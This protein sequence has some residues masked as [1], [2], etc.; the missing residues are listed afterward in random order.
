MTPVT[1]RGSILFWLDAL[2]KWSM[3]DI[4]VLIV[5]IA[6][7]R[8]SI[9]SPSVDFLPEGFY[10]VD[11]LVV[12]LWGLYANMI[13]QLIS[14]VSSHFIIYYHRRV[15]KAAL[16]QIE[17]H[18]VIRSI[19]TA[20]LTDEDGSASVDDSKVITK[21]VDNID[22]LKDHAFARPHR[23]EKDRLIARSGTSFALG[24]SAFALV[25]L[26]I[27]GSILP[28]FSLDVLGLAG[29]AI[30][31]GQEFRDASKQHS[32]FT[33]I[34]LLFEEARFL[35]T[36]KD[37]IGLG[38]LSIILILTVL[39]VP[40]VQAACLLRQWF[41]EMD[42]RRRWWLSVA[43]ETLQAWQYVEVYLASIIVAAWQIGPVSEFMINDYCGGVRRTLSMLSFYGII[44]AEDSQCFRVQAGIE[45]ATFILAAGA[46]ILAVM[47]SFVMKAVNQYERDCSE[48]SV[49]LEE[50]SKLPVLDSFTNE[51]VEAARRSITPPA[52]L[53]TDTFRWTLRREDA[54]ASRRTLH[55]L[56][57]SAKLGVKSSFLKSARD[58]QFEIE[59]DEDQLPSADSASM[60]TPDTES[61]GIPRMYTE[62]IDEEDPLASHDGSSAMSPDSDIPRLYNFEEDSNFASNEVANDGEEY[63]PNQYGM[64]MSFRAV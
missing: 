27:F 3:V 12:P 30:E 6:A 18:N 49:L 39:V 38:T 54:R 55:G 43:I 50:T 25:V 21:R 63:A 42:N 45:D 19:E 40:I 36:V 35:G 56:D 37:Y 48:I 26:V 4:F 31:S 53:F 33:V 52:V 11:L 13:A 58:G 61:C 34:A 29:I 8:V 23:G 44:D 5:S 28:S 2:A 1:K 16:Q 20:A 17:Q 59:A 7:F 62:M 10:T 46:V 24:L 60:L 64:S 41:V 14:Q 47:H 51:E 9:Q 15:I 57:D 32:V 22:S